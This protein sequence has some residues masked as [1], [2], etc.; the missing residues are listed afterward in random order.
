MNQNGQKMALFTRTAQH[1]LPPP[2]P[3]IR[4]ETRMSETHELITLP[5]DLSP[6]DAELDRELRKTLAAIHR[7]Y[8]ERCEPI[9]KQLAAI[10]A[11]YMPRVVIVP[12]P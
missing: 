2:P 1:P 5:P 3:P 7:E 9:T 4:T 12:K 6:E 8:Q 10:H 11:R